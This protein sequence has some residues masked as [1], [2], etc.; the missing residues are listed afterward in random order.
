MRYKDELSNERASVGMD[1]IRRE[2][3]QIVVAVDKASHDELSVLARI[4]KNTAKTKAKMPQAHE[5]VSEP[6][7]QAKETYARADSARQDAPIFDMDAPSIHVEPAP[8]FVDSNAV[9]EIVETHAEKHTERI[10]ES[11]P[12]SKEKIDKT[13]P[14]AVA[15]A[16]EAKSR[17]SSQLADEL[18]GFYEDDNGRLRKQNGAFA[19]HKQKELYDQ[20]KKDEEKRDDKQ[21]GMFEAFSKLVTGTMQKQVEDVDAVDAVGASVGNSA[22]QMVKEV[23]GFKDSATE[24]LQESGL[25]SVEGVK[26]KAQG[27]MNSVKGTRDRAKHFGKSL[28]KFLKS[29]TGFLRDFKERRQESKSEIFSKN[30]STRHEK[31]KIAEQQIELAQDQSEQLSEHHDEQ[32]DKLSDIESAIK[33]TAGGG[34]SG[35]DMF[36]FAEDLYDMKRGRKRGGRKSRMSARTADVDYYKAKESIK[37]RSA[38]RMSKVLDTVKTSS[39]GVLGLGDDAA[40]GGGVLSKLS[41]GGKSL[42]GGAGKLLKPLGLLL[43]IGAAGTALAAGDNRGASEEVGGMAGGVGG[44]MAGAATGAALL[45]VIPGIGTVLGGVIGGVLGGIGGD[46][47][48]R[49]AGGGLFD[50]FSSDE[51]EAKVKEESSTAMAVSERVDSSQAQASALAVENGSSNALAS[52]DE[53]FSENS[54]YSVSS[55]DAEKMPVAVGHDIAEEA[56]QG[57][58]SSYGSSSLTEKDEDDRPINVTAHLPSQFYKSLEKIGS[59]T[60]ANNPGRAASAPAQRAAASKE[61][62]N[63]ENKSVEGNIPTGLNNPELRLIAMDIR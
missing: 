56:E 43:G 53:I 58:S 35:L 7:A 51:P 28:G 61:Q 55:T 24:Y 10:V 6:E 50:M 29:P 62:A 57:A 30:S 47:V 13:Q 63:S 40:K 17:Q 5:V 11:K 14:E 12:T 2:L 18:K 31:E 16:Q 27:A 19:S 52:N 23:K 48:G 26:D 33:A 20:Q 37:P 34:A 42:L 44:A 15:E 8:V 3:A 46:L 32:I 49:S 9:S 36:D 59:N 21:T 1:N 60:S 38:S 39:K 25:D 4:E 54:P 22:W 45:S 41:G